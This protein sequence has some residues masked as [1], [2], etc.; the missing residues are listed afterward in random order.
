M[1]GLAFTIHF[2]WFWGSGFVNWVLRNE[3]GSVE[4]C[5]PYMF[6]HLQDM[7]VQIVLPSFSGVFLVACARGYGPVFYSGFLCPGCGL[8][9]SMVGLL[10]DA[11]TLPV[12]F[13]LG[14]LFRANAHFLCF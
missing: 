14:G 4:L 8:E 7:V 3:R 2:R 11:V 5:Y 1:G 9:V 12:G 10:V 13:G 6:V